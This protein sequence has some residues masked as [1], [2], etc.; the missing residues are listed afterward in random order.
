MF[1]RGTWV[2]L[3]TSRFGAFLAQAKATGTHDCQFTDNQFTDS[4]KPVFQAMAGERLV[5][6]EERWS[7][8]SVT[9]AVKVKTQAAGKSPSAIDATG[10]RLGTSFSLVGCAKHSA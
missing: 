6:C 10:R 7:Y 4:R 2:P 5:G 3:G 9:P 1:S 8:P